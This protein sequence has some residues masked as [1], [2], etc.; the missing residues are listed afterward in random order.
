MKCLRLITASLL[1]LFNTSCLPVGKQTFRSTSTGGAA[2]KESDAAAHSKAKLRREGRE[3]VVQDAYRFDLG[4]LVD[5]DQGYQ[6]SS[7]NDE[8]ALT[9]TEAVVSMAIHGAFGLGTF[10][11]VLGQLETPWA[12]GI[13]AQTRVGRPFF[14][15]SLSAQRDDYYVV[16]VFYKARWAVASHVGV[17]KRGTYYSD[18][19]T[20]PNQ[21]I[22]AAKSDSCLGLRN[23]EEMASRRFGTLT[24][25][26]ERLYVDRTPQPTEAVLSYV[27]W[28]Q[29]PQQDW[30][31]DV[32]GHAIA[33]SAEQ[34]ERLHANERME[35]PISFGNEKPSP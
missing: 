20:V 10:D 19:F 2:I 4:T 17:S 23:V 22:E 15:R 30:L 21:P 5:V 32:E 35:P 6:T 13:F 3:L 14:V 31:L 34:T 8:G 25:K 18:G 26:P 28:I 27:W 11:H 7:E 29:T 1:L 9:R 12:K 24:A 33:L 16:P